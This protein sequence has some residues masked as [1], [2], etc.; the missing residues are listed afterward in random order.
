M[1][2]LVDQNEPDSISMWVAQSIPTDRLLLNAPAIPSRP[3]YCW[4]NHEGK[5]VG[6]SRKQSGEFI[7]A[8]DA[9]ESQLLAEMGGVDYLGLLIEGFWSAAPDGSCYTWEWKEDR[10]YRDAE[11]WS[12]GALGY[13]RHH[14]RQSFKGVHQKLARLQDLGVMII[15]TADM[16]STATALVALYNESQKPD[17]MSTTFKRLI[18]EK[19]MVAEVDGPKRTLALQLMGAVPGIGEEIALAISDHCGTLFDVMSYLIDPDY[20]DGHVDLAKVPLRTGKRTVGPAA[21]KKLRSALGC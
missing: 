20:G 3:D 18:K 1:T 21:V 12:Y 6:I 14:F 11:P 5:L 7:G 8:I 4:Y 9:A 10:V 16:F 2:L 19:H 13:T 17:S 15:P